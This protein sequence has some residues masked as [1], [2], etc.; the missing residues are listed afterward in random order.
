[1]KNND[2]ARQLL[3]VF[4]E[5][6]VNVTDI[7]NLVISKMD[8]YKNDIPLLNFDYLPK[9]EFWPKGT[10]D[11]ETGIK[12]RVSYDGGP[13]MEH[14]YIWLSQASKAF[15]EAKPDVTKEIR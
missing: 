7:K 12:D 9:I 3:P 8:V 5:L 6:A 14:F 2:L 4:K 1:M 10:K 15:E 13:E 11:K